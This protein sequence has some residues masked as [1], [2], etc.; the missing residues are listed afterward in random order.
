MRRVWRVSVVVCAVVLAMGGPGARRGLAQ[1]PS[2]AL[3]SLRVTMLPDGGPRP[4]IDGTVDDEMWTSIQPFTEF[5]Q[6][7]PNEGQPASE[8]TEVRI[9]LDKT[10]LYIGVIAFDSEPDKIVV[11][12]SR[13]DADLAESDSV[14]VL[15][16]TFNDTQNAFIFGTNP[17]GIEYDGQVAG[18]GQTGGFQTSARAGTGGSQRGSISGFNANWDADWVVRSQVTTRGWETEMA[19]PL[20]TLRYAPGSDKTWGFNVLRNIRR[21]NEQVFLSPIPRGYTINQ[22]SRA[23]KL[24]GLNLP[25]R[26]DIKVTPFVATSIDKDYTVSTDSLQKKGDVGL[27]L[28]WGV[29][30]SLTVDLTVNTDFAQVEADDEQINLTRFELFFPEKRPFFLENAGIFQFGVPQTVDL[31]F[32]RRIGLSS[33][34]VPIGI[35][36]GG[37]LSGKVGGYNI[38]VLNMQTQETI[39]KRTGNALIAPANNFTVTR[40]QREV[41]RSNFGGIFV[42]RVA[43]GDRAGSNNWNRSYGVDS[44]IQTTRNGKLFLM[45]ARTDSPETNG[46]SDGAGRATYTYSNALWNGYVQYMQVGT[47]FNPEVGFLPRRGFREVEGR[48]F[49]TYDPKDPKYDWIRRVSPHISQNI[50]YGFDGQ[51]QSAR[52][53][54]H[55]F[56]I[57]PQAG[58]RFGWQVDNFQDRPVRPFV[59][60]SS[61]SGKRVVIPA[62]RLYNWTQNNFQWVGNAS[63]PI[64]FNVAYGFGGFYDGHDKQLTSLIGWRWRSKF[65]GSVGWNRDD[66]DLPAGSFHTDLVPIRV[67]YSFTSLASINALMQYNSQTD[68][69]SSNIRL[70]LLNRSGT[71]LFVVYNDRRDFSPYTPD[72]VLGRSFIVKYTRLFAF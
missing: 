8:K 15:L 28:K 4:K 55:F 34:G 49:L 63:A 40:V 10:T 65:S 38:G 51:V 64:Y 9:A 1:A 5:V 52:G 56:E 35:V 6:Q 11:T 17:N 25:A 18:E 48:A 71:G 67:G 26:R 20:K 27:D 33:S 14:Q 7:E 59:V 47:R 43:S 68:Q 69:M 24:G 30:P 22:V 72:E 36:G 32:S 19:I 42:G 62:N 54:Y 44:A 12:Q 2:P 41:G 29:T 31:F 39:N 23:A 60:Y 3:K 45:L 37:R 66:I 70:A 13:R 57:D 50:Y 53:H 61:P 58:G 16:D 21:K 46:G